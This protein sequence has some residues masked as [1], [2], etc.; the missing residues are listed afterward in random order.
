MGAIEAIRK[1]FAIANKN[2]GLAAIL[3]IFSLIG[4]FISTRFIEI[5]TAA[6]AAQLTSLTLVGIIVLIEIFIQGGTLGVIRDYIK[7]GKVRLTDFAKYGLKYYLRLLGAGLAIV[8][9]AIIVFIAGNLLMI[10]MAISKLILLGGIIA[11]IVTGIG[12]YLVLLMAALFPYEI[13]CGNASVMEALAGSID[14]TRRFINKFALLFLIIALIGLAWMILLK[15][16]PADNQTLTLI[17][18]GVFN[19]YF[20]VVIPASIMSFYLFVTAK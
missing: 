13:V 18:R 9:A 3:F 5:D 15:L 6:I 12:I 16:I 8:G 17:I 10:P 2:L 19:G 11:L 20:G 4:E 14:I 1:G 7:E